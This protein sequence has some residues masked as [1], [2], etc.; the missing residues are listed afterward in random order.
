MEDTVIKV[1]QSVAKRQPDAV[2]LRYK[3]KTGKWQTISFGELLTLAG[4]FGAGLLKLGVKR[5]EHV[6]IISDNRK[7]WI[8]ADLGIIGIGA[9]DVPRGSDTMP[10][11]ARYILNHA[12]CA[13]SLAENTTQVKKILSRKSD[14]PILKTIIVMDEDF[15]PE[16]LNEPSAGVA[17]HTF[18]RIMEMGKEHL[19]ADPQAFNKE[20]EKGKADGLFINTSGIG[21]IRP[22][23]V[24][25]GRSWVRSS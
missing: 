8:I 17:I 13:V 24:V 25:S 23:V 12:D 16:E 11:E 21:V 5:G 6:G 18:A 3:D 14:L 7:E 9:A 19:A 1:I 2:S 10:E 4:R 15:K 22:G 20:M